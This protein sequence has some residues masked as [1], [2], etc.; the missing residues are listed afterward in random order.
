MKLKQ[1]K[2]LLTS[3]KNFE[4]PII[5]LEQYITPYD[6]AAT[7]IYNAHFMYNDIENKNILDLCSGTGMLSVASSFFDPK[8]ITCVEYDKNSINICKENF[9]SFNVNNYTILELD[10]ESMNL[11]SHYDTTIMNPPFGTR[12]KGIDIK[13]LSIAL[14]HSDVVYS[15]H[16]RSTRE[17]L[18]SKFKNAEVIAEVQYELQNSYKFHKKQMKTIE[19]DLLRLTK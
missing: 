4:N 18:I 7:M 15:L 2:S 11:E 13:A 17:Y 1:L 9:E 6:I 10:I 12:N 5:E 3:V 19:V 14:L 16:K 8:S